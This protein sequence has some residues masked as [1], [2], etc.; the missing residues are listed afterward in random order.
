MMLWLILT[1]ITAFAALYV[2]APFLRPGD[3]PGTENSGE[4]TIFRDQLAEIDKDAAAGT[5]EPAAAEQARAEIKRRLL[6]ADKAASRATPA[7]PLG[8]LELKFA[9]LAVTGLTVLGSAI[10]YAYS[11]N[12]ALPSAVPG[13]AAQQGQPAPGGTAGGAPSPAEVD[14]LIGK[15]KDRIKAEPKNAKLQAML[16]WTYMGT[17]KFADAVDAYRKAVAIDGKNAMLQIGLADALIQLANGEVTPEAKTV[18]AAALALAPM[19]PRA[20][21]LQ[22]LAKNQ[23]GDAKG[24][25]EDWIA[26]L[27][28]AQPGDAWAPEVRA[29]VE[30]LAKEA[31][32]DLTGRL[33]AAT[34]AVGPTSGDVA[35]A[36]KMSDADRMA[37]ITG[38]VERLAK[39]LEANPRDVEGWMQLMRARK[40][41]GDGDGA[42][43]ALK[44]ALEVFADSP[45]DRDKL[46]AAAA[47]LGLAQ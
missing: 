20:L 11:G 39:K 9:F 14:N 15:L 43:A 7:R 19:E 34:P 33:P 44:R 6:A 42:R 23:A 2:A 27:G 37:M 41:M 38:M 22:G 46:N 8:P 13:S 25:V 16:G 1:A 21:F 5:I 40:V 28:L 47:D 26:V 32:I 3:Q 29:R 30:A 17:G 31:K 12:P 10:L 24:A 35:A 45:A 18:V 4:F 36:E